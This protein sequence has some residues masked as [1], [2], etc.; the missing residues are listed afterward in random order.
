MPDYTPYNLLPADFFKREPLQNQLEATR[1]QN[2]Q[3]LQQLASVPGLQE[4]LTQL[5]GQAAGLPLMPHGSADAGWSAAGEHE[6]ALN[7]NRNSAFQTM[8]PESKQLLDFYSNVE[9][10]ATKA[11]NERQQLAE[12]LQ[13]LFG[14]PQ[15]PG[16][17]AYIAPP[18]Q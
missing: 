5:I 1:V 18:L 6:A 16:P 17:R 4:R 7:P 9:N 13:R 8:G 12:Q 3:A 10:P 14:M 15:L 11:L 2:L